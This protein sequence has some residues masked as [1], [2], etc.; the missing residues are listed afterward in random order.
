MASSAAARTNERIYAAR[1]QLAAY[2]RAID[3]QQAPINALQVAFGEAVIFQLQA[4]YRAYLA[5]LG[6]QYNAPE[7]VYQCVAELASAGISG[8]EVN[9]LVSLEQHSWL[10]ELLAAQVGNAP[11]NIRYQAR[12]ELQFVDVSGVG[13]SYDPELL[14]V[15][16]SA[17]KALIDNQRQHFIEW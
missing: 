13:D 1:L 16:L 2:R 14:T 3:E 12:A 6:R 8:A 4:S 9:E 11:N 17:L 5:E 15:W 10:A 7:S